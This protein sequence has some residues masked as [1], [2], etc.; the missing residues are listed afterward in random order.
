MTAKH[1]SRDRE[2]RDLIRK[3]VKTL[4]KAVKVTLGPRGRNVVLERSFGAPTITKDG[5]TV[6]KE[7]ELADA[8]ENMGC[9]MVREVA[10]RTN[11]AAGDGTTTATVLAEAIFEAGL[12]NL[13]AGVN[14]IHL[15]R[16][17]D[18]AVVA[19]KGALAAA[20]RPVSGTKDLEQVARISANNDTATGKVIAEAF[21]KVGKEGAVTVDESNGIE[22]TL[23]IVEGLEFDRGYLSPNFITHPELRRCELEDVLVLVHEKK[24]GNVRDLVP[25]LEAV[26]RAGKAILI[27]AED[28]EG[29]AL[30][31]LVVNRLRGDLKVCAVKAPGFGDRRK[32]MLEDIAVVTGGRAILED[33]GDKLE[34]LK[35]EDLGR[36]AKVI[37]DKDSTAII[38]G[39]GDATTI[40]ARAESLKAQIEDT[41]SDYDREKLEERLA[42]LAGGVAKV[43][44][45]ASTESEL[46]Q[47]KALVEDAIN[48]TRAAL[49]EGIVPGGGVALV[50][51]A[52]AIDALDLSAEERV[53]A[54]I[55]RASLEAPLRQ[56]VDNAGESASVVLER[57]R[58]KDD[59]T[60]G[61]D[62][63]TLQYGDMLE[64]GIVDPAK[65]TR[66]ALENAASVASLLLTTEALVGEAPKKDKKGKKKSSGG[67]GG[68]YDDDDYG[69]DDWD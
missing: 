47:R 68:G 23:S 11:D 15:K 61:F 50:L 3:G 43:E 27:I 54:D 28:I 1:V 49:E 65:V 6:A 44:V 4:A 26:I 18:K 33:T 55:L 34:N 17:I 25:I 52:K 45:G 69:D 30:A 62:A 31:T 29:D 2:A 16:G 13:I 40:K 48:A 8:R 51:A 21:E 9:Q 63:D 37:I 19:V 56:I 58:E 66:S 22:T 57:I 59:P 39:G 7:I 67:G 64:L 32:A 12:R 53:G 46:K 36:A 10:S 20:S 60:F 14:P 41:T 24:I 35:L 5:V 42:K 38:E